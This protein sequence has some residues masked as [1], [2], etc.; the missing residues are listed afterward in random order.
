MT[1][2]RLLQRAGAHVDI[3]RA[4]PDLFKLVGGSNGQTGGSQPRGVSA[5][6]RNATRAGQSSSQQGTVREAILDIVA[7]FPGSMRQH[8]IDVTIHSPFVASCHNADRKVA[9]AATAAES[10]K[11]TRYGASVLPVA[12]E[13]CG[14]LGFKSIESLQFLQQ[15]ALLWG[16][17]LQQAR[18]LHWQRELE[19]VVAFQLADSAL[20]CLGKSSM[21]FANVLSRA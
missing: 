6:L 8:R 12:F 1:L 20:I 16:I 13:T 4:C 5:T 14:R 17:D 9:S 15:E 21:L 2:A 7:T 10:A 3:E 11:K 18:L 19:T